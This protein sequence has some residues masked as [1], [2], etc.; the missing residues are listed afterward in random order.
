MGPGQGYGNTE[1]PHFDR[2]AQAAHMSRQARIFKRRAA[3]G[4]DK[5]SSLFP[6]EFGADISQFGGFFAV[7][8][9]L[10]GAIAL[11]YMVA[12]MWSSKGNKETKRRTD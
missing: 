12:A 7:L 9:V 1:I 8:A 6:S 4:T 10:G 11:Q 5:R 3:S 2:A